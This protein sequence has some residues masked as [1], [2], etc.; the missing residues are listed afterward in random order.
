MGI[1]PEIGP[2]KNFLVPPKFGARSPPMGQ[3]SMFRPADLLE[4]I[5]Y[6]STSKASLS[7]LSSLLMVQSLIHTASYSI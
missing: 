5:L 1:F 4:N 3:R 6:D 2:R 7:F